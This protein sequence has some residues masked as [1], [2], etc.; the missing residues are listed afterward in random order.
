MAPDLLGSGFKSNK[1][2]DRKSIMASYQGKNKAGKFYKKNY[3]DK[4]FLVLL[5]A[6]CIL[7]SAEL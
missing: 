4:Q 3:F 7:N 5:Y 6:K 2:H 1:I